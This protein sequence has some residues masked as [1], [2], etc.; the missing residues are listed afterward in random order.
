MCR[1]YISAGWLS[2]RRPVDKSLH[3]VLHDI[4]GHGVAEHLIA[5]RVALRCRPL[6]GKALQAFAFKRRETAQLRL[7]NQRAL[8]VVVDAL[9]IIAI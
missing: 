5:L 3:D 2:I 4:D 9:I 6:I 1:W 8:F 7:C